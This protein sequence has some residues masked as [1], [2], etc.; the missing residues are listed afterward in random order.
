[1]PDISLICPCY[2][3]VDV[4]DVFLEEVLSVLNE[5]GRPYE[6]IFVND[7]STDDTLEKLKS[8]KAQNSFIRILNLSRNFGKEA[9][10][11][12]GIDNAKGEVIIPIDVDLQHPPRLLIQFIEK[13]QNGYE[14]VLGKRKN[15]ETESSVKRLTATLF[16]KLTQK[17]SNVYVPENVGDFRLMTR[18]VVNAIK[19]LPENQRFMKGLFAWVGFKTAV[20]EFDVAQRH[21]GK[22]SFNIWKL[23]NFA[24]DGITS[25]STVPLRIWS[26]I[27]LIISFM[28]LLYGNIVL[29]QTFIFGIDAPGYASTIISILFLG[30]IQLIGIGV[31]GEYIGRIYMESK[32][33]PA[34]IIEN[35]Y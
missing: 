31:L 24:L 33:R 35:E 2:N 14:V 18:K 10:L 28:A 26:Y 32:R 22:T 15:R 4:V 25:F 12:A 34:Y 16:Y 8:L 13:W 6:I 29:V 3:E 1:M 19:Q 27:G 21:A 7:G 20:V 30:G 17:I 9:A 11:T 5:I 23:W